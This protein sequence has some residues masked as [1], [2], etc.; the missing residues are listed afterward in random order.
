MRTKW[1]LGLLLCFG[2]PLLGQTLGDVS[3]RVSDPSGAGVPNAVVTLT[4]TATNAARTANTS[5]EGFYTF[6]SVPPGIYNIKVEHPG[7]R[8]VSSTNV[9]VQV[10]QT[11][12][13]D[14]TLQVGQ[15]SETVEVSAQA[16]SVA[17]RKRDRRHR[18]REPGDLEASAQRPRIPESGGAGSE[19]QHAVAGVRSG[20]V[21]PGRRPCQPVDLRRRQPHH[22]RLFHARR[23]QQHR[24]SISTPMSCFPRSTR[25]RNSKCRPACIPA[26][27]GHEAT[28]INVL[29][30]SGGNA[31]HGSLFEFVR[32][33]DFDAKPYAFTTTRPGASPFKWNDY[34]F[35][36]D[37]PVPFRSSSM[38]GTGCSSCPTTSG[39]CSGRM[40]RR[41]YSVPTA[42]MFQGN[43]SQI[44]NIIYDPDHRRSLTRQHH[45]D[46]P[47]Q[48][49]LAEAFA[50]TT[51]LPLAGPDQQLRPERCLSLK[52]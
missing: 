16:D 39:W 46:E 42:A 25:S 49:D 11:V 4:N 14:L 30:K 37:G 35:E 24:S 19:R 10:Q 12:R 9:E 3:G 20:W 52:P 13:L 51:L 6:T 44:S 36:I 48:S 18:G 41:V 21:A 43:F 17:G 26:E 22:V 8:T 7:F 47:H 29:T 15:V 40:R 2:L 45:S 23:R 34:G 33:D 1:F 32:N 27:F 38:A 50:S 31:Y 28:Q 5:G